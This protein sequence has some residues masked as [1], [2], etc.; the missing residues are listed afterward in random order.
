[1]RIHGWCC[2]TLPLP[3]KPCIVSSVL[4]LS[5]SYHTHSTSQARNAVVLLDPCLSFTLR[6]DLSEIPLPIP[7]IFFLQTLS[8]QGL[9]LSKFSVLQR[10]CLE[11]LDYVIFHVL[12]IHRIKSYWQ[13]ANYVEWVKEG[14]KKVTIWRCRLRC[15][16]ELEKQICEYH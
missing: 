7:S 12:Q 16:P 14:R 5:G 4:Y 9:L 2:L 3:P 1:M 10:Q 15:G 6:F 13:Y 8:G 11:F